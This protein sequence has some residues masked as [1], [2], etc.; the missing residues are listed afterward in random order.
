MYVQTAKLEIRDG[1]HIIWESSSGASTVRHS[2][3]ARVL[4]SLQRFMR[5][6][7]PQDGYSYQQSVSLSV[8]GSPMSLTHASPARA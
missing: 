8:S 6:H 4:T 2:T 1:H 7:S 3:S 5:Q